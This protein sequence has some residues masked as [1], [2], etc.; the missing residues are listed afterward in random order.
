MEEVCSS[1]SSLSSF[2][3]HR[4]VVAEEH[5]SSGE[6][7]G[8]GAGLWNV[9][10]HPRAGSSPGSHSPLPQFLVPVFLKLPTG[11]EGWLEVR[12]TCGVAELREEMPW[13]GAIPVGA[14]GGF[15]VNRRIAGGFSVF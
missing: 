10:G 9:Q 2:S 11:T 5:R 15:G 1:S 13:R 8:Y 14:R 7:A 12:G 4:Q 3:S 6:E